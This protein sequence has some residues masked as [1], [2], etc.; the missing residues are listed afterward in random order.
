MRLRLSVKIR[1]EVSFIICFREKV[2]V[3]VKFR[4]RVWTALEFIIDIRLRVILWIG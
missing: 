1:V 4:A 3:S 2:R